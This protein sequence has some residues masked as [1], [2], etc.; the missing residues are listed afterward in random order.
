[1]VTRCQTQWVVSKHGRYNK[2]LTRF[3]FLN[4]YKYHPILHDSIKIFPPFRKQLSETLIWSPM[5]EANPNN[6]GDPSNKK[7]TTSATAAGGSKEVK[8]EDT[9]S[10]KPH[11]IIPMICENALLIFD[12]TL[13]TQRGWIRKWESWRPNSTTTVLDPTDDDHDPDVG[14]SKYSFFI[15]IFVCESW[16]LISRSSMVGQKNTQSCL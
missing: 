16:F 9:G 5:A 1:M 11:V 6:G 12:W 14:S 15:Q 13:E 7:N 8:I 10:S 4:P 2:I 3:R